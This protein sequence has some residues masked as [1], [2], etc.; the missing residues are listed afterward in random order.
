VT[1]LVA[2]YG[3]GVTFLVQDLEATVTRTAGVAASFIKEL[4]RKA[5]L[6]A[7]E[8]ADGAGPLT[9]TDQHLQEALGELLEERSALTRVLLGGFRPE[10]PGRR[11]DVD[12]LLG[13][14]AESGPP[15]QP[16]PEAT[17]AHE[18]EG[19]HPPGA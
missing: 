17:T 1:C 15:R 8:G 13:N 10:E 19:A 6:L 9:V 18:A 16:Q 14:T 2:L 12:W 5:A 7:A 3:S 4:V 11:R